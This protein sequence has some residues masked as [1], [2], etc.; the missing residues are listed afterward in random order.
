MAKT[1]V[2]NNVTRSNRK[3]IIGYSITGFILFITY[4]FLIPWEG[5]PLGVYDAVYRWM[6]PSAINESLVYVIMA[7]G[8]N[9]VVG[10]AGL[11]DLGCSLLGNW[12]ILRRL[13]YVRVF[14][15]LK[16]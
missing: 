13:V 5:L 4:Q 9:I 6:P 11:L 16:H 8:L 12:W 7:L 15:L 14:L 10:Y 2:A 3:W 1:S